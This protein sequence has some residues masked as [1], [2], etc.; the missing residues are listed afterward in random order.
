MRITITGPKRKNT[1]SDLLFEAEISYAGRWIDLD[2]KTRF[3]MTPEGFGSEVHAFDRNIAQSTFFAGSITVNSKPTTIEMVREID[4]LGG[5][6][7]EMESN[8]ERL[9]SWFTQ[10]SFIYRERHNDVR[11]I[12][13]CEAA[14]YAIMQTHEYMH[15]VRSKVRFTFR[16][17]PEVEMEEV[18]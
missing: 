5:S 3:E 18:L 8:V 11:R 16:V 7:F 4:V 12:Y 2:D 9:V 10:R 15:N 13:Q 1:T 17:D 14:D 6:H